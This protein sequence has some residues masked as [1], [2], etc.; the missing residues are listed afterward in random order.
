MLKMKNLAMII[1]AIA[2]STIFL[3]SLAYAQAPSTTVNIYAWTDKASYNPGDKG[4]LK[5]VV[6][7]DRT[8]QDLIIKNITVFYPWFVYTGDQWEGN[9]TIT[10]STPPVIVKKG[11]TYT[12]SVDFNIPADGRITSMYGYQSIDIR[13]T[14]DKSPYQYPTSGYYQVPIYISITPSYMDQIVTLFT[15]QVVL[16][17][18]CTIIVAATIFLAMR[19]PQVTWKAEEK[20][21]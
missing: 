16:I 15:V 10:E 3:T 2:V 8:D 4:T 11:G 7:N 21:E 19:R 12:K 14:V 13:V 20:A 1:A 18:V 17:I 9:D 5:I 6:R